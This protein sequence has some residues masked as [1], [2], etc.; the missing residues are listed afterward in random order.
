MYN[1]GYVQQDYT[2]STTP[3]ER[4]RDGNTG[5]IRFYSD[6]QVVEGEDG[7]K[8]L[9][10]HTFG[11]EGTGEQYEAD[12]SG[13]GGFELG[14]NRFLSQKRRFGWEVGIGFNGFDSDYKDAV[15][16]SLYGTKYVHDVV[17][18]DP[19]IPTTDDDDDDSTPEVPD[20]PYTGDTSRPTDADDLADYVLIN[21]DPNVGG[22]GTPGST[23]TAEELS[24]YTATVDSDMR[25][26]SS[27]FTLRFGPTY[28]MELGHRFSL[29]M[30]AGV[31]T[32][33][34]SGD[35]DA[36]EY[37]NIEELGTIATT[38]LRKES[39]NEVLF[40]GYVQTTA[41]YQ[42]NERVN[43]YSGF[44]YQ[45]SGNFEMQGEKYNVDVDMGSQMFVKTGFGVAF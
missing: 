12:A 44:Q 17:N 43:F 32:M 27:M 3:R 1:D 9:V 19:A 24:Q 7:S 8:D 5:N 10:F 23:M 15:N 39:D 18:G 25:F 33:Y 36:I 16:S 14:Y 4:T 31:S 13:A 6:D 40:G 38:G 21:L 28:N 35:L 20:P 30:G 22:D 29:S 41:A 45:S 11:A 2:S 42:I 34:Y 26:R 37:L